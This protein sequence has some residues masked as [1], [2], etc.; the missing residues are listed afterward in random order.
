[1]DFYFKVMYP[2]WQNHR[3]VDAGGANLSGTSP[4]ISDTTTYAKRIG[5]KKN[6]IA[7]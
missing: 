7:V 5:S 1:M 2:S 4:A 6:K 3:K